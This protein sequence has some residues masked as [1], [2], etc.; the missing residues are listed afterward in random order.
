MVFLSIKYFLRLE[1]LCQHNFLTLHNHELGHFL[2]SLETFLFRKSDG[3]YQKVCVLIEKV[4]I[5]ILFVGF[6]LDY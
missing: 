1:L 5:R 2:Q 3:F 4:M 6:Q